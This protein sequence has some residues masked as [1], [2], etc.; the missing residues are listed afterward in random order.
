M[1]FGESLTHSISHRCDFF[2]FLAYKSKLCTESY[3]EYI[4]R[5]F[6]HFVYKNSFYLSCRPLKLNNYFLCVIVDLNFPVYLFIIFLPGGYNLICQLFRSY[7]QFVLVCS[8]FGWQELWGGG[9]GHGEGCPRWILCSMVKKCI[10]TLILTGGGDDSTQPF[11]E[12]F[13]QL[14]LGIFRGV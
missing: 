3:I 13:S 8:G 9:Y 11:K 4:Y 12:L 6:I 2:D 1:R 5:F 14:K 10:L 7:G